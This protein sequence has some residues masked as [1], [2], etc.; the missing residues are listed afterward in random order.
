VTFDRHPNT[1]VAPERVPPL[2]YSL[3]QRIRAIGALGVDTTWLIRFDEAFSR[4]PGEAFVR[5]LARG[6]GHLHSVCV[7]AAFHFGHKRSG[8]VAVLR[9][10]GA[11][12]HFVVHGLAAV[13][14]DGRVISSTR[15][16]EVIRAGQFDAASEMLGRAYSL[17]GTVQKGD[18]LGR[19]LGYPTA[20]LEVSGLALP[21]DGVYAVHA[22]VAGKSHRAVLNLGIRPTVERTAPPTRVEAHLLDFNGDLYGQELEV[23]FVA[24]LRDER[25]FPDLAALKKQIAA[26][27]AAARQLFGS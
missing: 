5:S 4:Q 25:K 26:D 27:I 14:L 12:L 24:R 6:F 13:A 7:G 1:V 11:E 23:N 20:N 9:A 16:R 15:I 2:I 17:C 8:N 21:P 10:L 22:H 19:R 18:Q 3:P